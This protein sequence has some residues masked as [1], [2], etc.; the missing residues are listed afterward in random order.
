[1][2][3]VETAYERLILRLSCLSVSFI[4]LVVFAFA[5]EGYYECG[6]QTSKDD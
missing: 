4:V 3:T 1:M 2:L 6:R 5:D